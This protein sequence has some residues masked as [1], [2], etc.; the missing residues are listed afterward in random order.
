MPLYRQKWFLAT[1]TVVAAVFLLLMYLKIQPNRGV[2]QSAED[3]ASSPAVKTGETWKSIYFADEKIGYVRSVLKQEE[4]GAYILEETVFFRF[5]SMGMVHDI[6]L[7]TSARLKTDFSLDRFDFDMSS[8]LMTVSASGRVSG[9]EVVIE[10]SN[11][12]TSGKREF[13]VQVDK[14]PYLV[15]GMLMDLARSGPPFPDQKDYSLFDPAFMSFSDATVSYHG[16]QTVSVSGSQT[17][18]FALSLSFK[19]F[20][21]KI[22]MDENGRSLMEKGLMGMKMVADSKSNA[23]DGIVRKPGRDIT[24]MAAVS[25]S[26]LIENPENLAELK[27]KITGIDPSGFN[28][29][30]HRQTLSGNI[31]TIRK[32]T[33]PDPG[34]TLKNEPNLKTF[35][36]PEP[37]IQSDHESVIQKAREITKDADSDLEK[38]RC[39]VRWVHYNIRKTP[40]VTV[41]SAL[42]TLESKKGDC[43]EHAVLTAAL[44]RA[45]DI[46]C[47]VETGLYYL[48]GKFRY[49]AWNA[50]YTGGWI[51]GD[52]VFNQIPADVTHISLT[53]GEARSETALAGIIG[54]IKLEPVNK[55]SR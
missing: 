50:F 45:V 1:G 2:E 42:S 43:N 20:T 51:T 41:P 54:R 36:E 10:T 33:L 47:R 37:F 13:R 4:K 31:L 26:N 12:D 16:K 46:P 27:V 44:A 14:K 23:L 19:G 22:W 53:S 39:I 40:V 32:E 49:H 28:L 11:P 38:I 29:S 30:N 9:D 5:N 25:F 35:T 18:A 48:N 15:S 55:E 7:D 21:Q 3:L 6:S 34:D 24:D 52:A 17:S 8:G